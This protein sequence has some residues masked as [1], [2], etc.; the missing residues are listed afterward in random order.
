MCKIVN[1]A[2]FFPERIRTVVEE[3]PNQRMMDYVDKWHLEPGQCH[4]G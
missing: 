4:A 3:K 1:P 2:N